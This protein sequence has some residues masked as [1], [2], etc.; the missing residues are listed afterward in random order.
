MNDAGAI[1]R[2]EQ[3]S[4]GATGALFFVR[5]MGAVN[6]VAGFVVVEFSGKNHN[7]LQ[8]GW[9]AFFCLLLSLFQIQ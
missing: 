9:C 8:I 1:R 5:F 4:E 6:F 7:C 3:V 2:L